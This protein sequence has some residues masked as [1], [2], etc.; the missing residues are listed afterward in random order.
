[1]ADIKK[2][3]DVLQIV[4]EVAALQEHPTAKPLDHKYTDLFWRQD[5][6]LREEYTNDSAYDVNTDTYIGRGEVCGTAMCFAG[7]TAWVDGYREV[8]GQSGYMVNPKTDHKLANHEIEKYAKD[9][10]LLNWEQTNWLFDGDNEIADIEEAISEI[11]KG[12]E[13]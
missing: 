7:W 8:D 4:K 1:M 2:L 9:S 11:E 3:K 6:W 12:Q 13:A 10:L 5:E